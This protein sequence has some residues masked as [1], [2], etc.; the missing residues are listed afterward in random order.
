MAGVGSQLSW[1]HARSAVAAFIEFDGRV[2]HGE[3]V[4]EV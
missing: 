1:S 2:R 3:V 4:E